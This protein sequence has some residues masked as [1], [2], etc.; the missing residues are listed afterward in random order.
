MVGSSLATCLNTSINFGKSLVF[1]A[2]TATVTTG[3]EMWSNPSNSLI[4]SS[5]EQIVSPAIAPF[6]PATYTM[7]PAGTA[8]VLTL[9]GPKYTPTC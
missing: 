9:S 5:G 6:E 2:S 3:S 1:L 8:S 4:L 7:L